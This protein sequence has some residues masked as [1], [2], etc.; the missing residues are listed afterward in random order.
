MDARSPYVEVAKITKVD[1]MRIIIHIK[2][3]MTEPITTQQDH[4]RRIGRLE[5]IAEQLDRRLDAIER[6]IADLRASIR[7]IIGILFGVV[8][9]LVTI[10][11]K[12]LN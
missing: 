11:L 6:A 4:D 12:V 2:E 10:L 3:I 7:W 9:L 5:G 1:R 8:G